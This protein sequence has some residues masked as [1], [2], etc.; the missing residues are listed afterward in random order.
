MNFSLYNPPTLVAIYLI[1]ESFVFFFKRPKKYADNRD[2]GSFRLLVLTILIC[3][4][5]GRLVKVTFPQGQLEILQDMA[6]VGVLLFFVGLLVRWVP[7][8]HLG[9]L[10]TIEVVITE[11]HK[12]IE[13][14]LYR[15]VRHPSYA[16]LMMMFLGIGIC[17][18]NVFTLLVLTAPLFF[19]LRHRMSIEEAAL[20]DAFGDRYANYMRKT[21]RLIPLLY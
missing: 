12:L 15:L 13:S 2:D 21:K 6:T 20:C 16:G 18:G 3:V 7:I 5:L 1:M 17:S 14:G 8:I 19:A 10:F 9:R 11:E 4:P